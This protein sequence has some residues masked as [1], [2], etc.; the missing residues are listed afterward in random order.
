MHAFRPKPL[1]AALTLATCL[2]LP[3]AEAAFFIVNS[4]LDVPE[5]TPGNG[6][7]SRL[8]P[9]RFWVTKP[10]KVPFGPRYAT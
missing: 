3:Q 5:A 10:E 6:T 1:L 9:N 8:P 4:T 2:G 7:C